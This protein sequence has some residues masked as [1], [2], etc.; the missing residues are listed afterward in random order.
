MFLLD[1]TKN[2]LNENKLFL[3]KIFLWF[4]KD[5]GSKKMMLE[6]ITKYSKINLMQSKVNYLSYNWDLNE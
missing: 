3:S 6:F 2:Q 1:K 4:G 5:F